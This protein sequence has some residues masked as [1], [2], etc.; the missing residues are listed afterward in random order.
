MNGEESPLPSPFLV[1]PLI[2]SLSETLANIDLEHMR[3]LQRVN[4]SKAE[5]SLKNE[6][7]KT[8][9]LRHQERREPYVQQLATLN[10][11]ARGIRDSE[12]A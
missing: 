11:R 2:E 4:R 12:A 9:S 5:P 7:R 1:R 6:L 3:E 10:A 8:L